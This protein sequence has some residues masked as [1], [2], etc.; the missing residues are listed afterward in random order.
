MAPAKAV[1]IRRIPRVATARPAIGEQCAPAQNTWSA[2]RNNK[3]VG[4]PDV[5]LATIAPSGYLLF[6]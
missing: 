5:G 6:R 2:Y 1:P 4:L 3:Y